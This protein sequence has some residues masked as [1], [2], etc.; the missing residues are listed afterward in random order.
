M[1]RCTFSYMYS[2]QS[3]DFLF[4]K[5]S[6]KKIDYIDLSQGSYKT[7]DEFLSGIEHRLFTLALAGDE[8]DGSEE[9][10]VNVIFRSLLSVCT[11]EN[12]KDE[13]ESVSVESIDLNECV[14][15]ANDQAALRAFKEWMSTSAKLTPQLI[16]SVSADSS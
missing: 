10:S 13:S 2:Q 8:E 14:M 1:I 6:E 15:T 9:W 7:Q 4:M 11:R 5:L 12:G 16:V 3:S